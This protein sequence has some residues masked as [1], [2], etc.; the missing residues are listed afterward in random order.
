MKTQL[1]QET[2]DKL[3][4]RAREVRERAYVPYSHFPVGAAV[5]T[6]SG[7]IFTGVNIE[8]ASY[9]LSICAERSAIFQ[10]ITA[11]EREIIALAVTADTARPVSPCGACRQVMNEFNPKMDVMMLNLTGDELRR[12]AGEL[13]PEHFSSGDLEQS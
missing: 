7:K 12:T 2:K 10:A 1:D 3:K 13:L 6:A 5:L 4:K 8:N 9:P 11:G